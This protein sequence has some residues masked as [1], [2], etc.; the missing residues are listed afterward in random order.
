MKILASLPDILGFTIF[1]I[2][3]FNNH[4]I[5]TYDTTFVY[6]VAIVALYFFK[7]TYEYQRITLTIARIFRIRE[8]NTKVDVASFQ[9]NLSSSWIG[10]LAL[11]QTLLTAL[12][13]AYFL[14]TNWILL[15]VVILLHLAPDFNPLPIPYSLLFRII[16]KEFAKRKKE[17]IQ[18]LA[19]GGSEAIGVSFYGMLHEAAIENILKDMPHDKMYE[20][21]AFKEYGKR[22]YE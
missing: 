15:G 21:W 22:L 16:H 14:F 9:A 3:L 10:A 17:R 11:V 5:K 19:Q 2:L 8:E 1:I 13:A 6:V 7:F 12:A 18:K 4:I 20:K